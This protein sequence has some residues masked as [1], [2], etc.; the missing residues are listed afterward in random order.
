MTA[1][2][3]ATGCDVRGLGLVDDPD[4]PV[5]FGVDRQV[6]GAAVAVGV[7]GAALA[8]AELVDVHAAEVAAAV[9]VDDEVPGG[10][11]GRAVVGPF[12]F[13]CGG[14]GELG[15]VLLA[16]AAE[17]RDG[18]RGWFRSGG[19]GGRCRGRRRRGACRARRGRGGV[20]AA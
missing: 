7:G 2:P 11:E 10:A 15:R 12:Q 1:S 20:A 13:P 17:L 6:M 4:V 16:A 18:P 5:A 8:V 3:A 9:F 14:D 19:L